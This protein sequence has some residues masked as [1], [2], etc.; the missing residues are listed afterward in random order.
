[1]S[2]GGGD[3]WEGMMGGVDRRG[4]RMGEL[5]CSGV[6]RPFS[7]TTNKVLRRW[8]RARRVLRLLWLEQHSLH[9]EMIPLLLPIPLIRRIT[10]HHLLAPDL[11]SMMRQ[12]KRRSRT[13]ESV[14]SRIEDWSPLLLPG[15]ERRKGGR[16][17]IL[18]HVGVGI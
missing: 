7:W 8:R 3:T 9:L 4:K 6:G 16:I 10:P 1:M 11:H 18:F 17:I 15:R 13:R 5:G 14:V 2:V 12:M